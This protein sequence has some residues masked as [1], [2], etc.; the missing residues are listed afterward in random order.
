MVEDEDM[1]HWRLW[2]NAQDEAH[3]DD[4]LAEVM[5]IAMMDWHATIRDVLERGLAGR[6]PVP[7]DLAAAAW[8]VAAVMDGLAGAMLVKGSIMTVS[9]ARAL[10]L[11]QLEL[12]GLGQ[13]QRQTSL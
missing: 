10:I 12:E 13:T 11:S 2:L 8:R 5:N 4:A 9:Q 1:R 6:T 7:A 3:R